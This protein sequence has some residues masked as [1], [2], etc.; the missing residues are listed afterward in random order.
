MGCNNGPYVLV[1]NKYLNC[2]V[3]STVPTD[4]SDVARGSRVLDELFSPPARHI[5]EVYRRVSQ[6]KTEHVAFITRICTNDILVD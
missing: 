6:R 2:R 1:L 3:Q 5:Y 4:L